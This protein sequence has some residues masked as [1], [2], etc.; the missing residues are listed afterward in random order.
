ME[1]IIPQWRKEPFDHSGGTFELKYDFRGMADTAHGRMPSKNGNHMKRYDTL[2]VGLPSGCVFDGR[3][4][5]PRPERSTQF[6]AL[7][8][9]YV[10][11]DVLFADGDDLRSS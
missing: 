3:D 9:I 6:N 5:G 8:P 10:A 2:L 1:P 4:R 11:F 7:L